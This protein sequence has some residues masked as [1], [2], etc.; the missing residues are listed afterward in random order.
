[1][2]QQQLPQHQVAQLYPQM[3]FPQFANYL[4]YRQFIPPMYVPQMA[5][6]NYSNNPAY[7]HPS[8]GSSYVLMQG[9]GSQLN[10]AGFKYKPVPTSSNIGYGNYTNPA[11]YSINGVTSNLDDANMIKYK[12]SNFFVPNAQVYIF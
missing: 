5:V 9:G 1:M 11:A 12:D 4:P 7:P 8:N 6:P 10:A 3:Q 2:V